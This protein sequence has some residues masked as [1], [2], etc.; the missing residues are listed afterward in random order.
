MCR[1]GH[2]LSWTWSSGVSSGEFPLRKCHRI[3]GSAYPWF[4]QNKGERGL[5]PRDFLSSLSSQRFTGP[6]SV[7]RLYSQGGD[8][9]GFLLFP[10]NL[11]IETLFTSQ[12]SGWGK[13][14]GSTWRGAEW[15]QRGGAAE[16]PTPPQGPAEG[17]FFF[18]AMGCL[19]G[20]KIL[21]FSRGGR[22]KQVLWGPLYEGT[23][24]FHEIP[25]SRP[26]HL[27]KASLP[28]LSYWGLGFQQMNFEGDTDIQ[29]IAVTVCSPRWRSESCA[30][31]F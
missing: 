30:L 10:E 28:I 12:S 31:L 4:Y 25:S 2:L 29:T 3:K 18:N 17:T 19:R 13:N 20:C 22:G 5:K 23:N 27:L 7:L 1:K 21:V 9:S 16:W 24:P 15:K 6:S 14:P 11:F 26:H 8:T